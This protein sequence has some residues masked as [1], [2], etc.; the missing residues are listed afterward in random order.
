MFGKS[1][2]LNVIFMKETGPNLME[3]IILFYY[4]ILN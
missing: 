4:I 2:A 1:Q 3:K